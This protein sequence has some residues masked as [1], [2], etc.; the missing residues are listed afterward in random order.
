[1]ALQDHECLTPLKPMIKGELFV[2]GLIHNLE[3]MLDELK[4]RSVREEPP[5]MQSVLKHHYTEDMQLYPDSYETLLVHLAGIQPYNPYT[6]L[7]S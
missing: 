6:S 2:K 4:R 3:D 5:I 1:M 7:E